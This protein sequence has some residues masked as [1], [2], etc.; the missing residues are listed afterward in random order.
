MTETDAEP[1]I[2]HDEVFNAA[3]SILGWDSETV[4]INDTLIVDTLGYPNLT[5]FIE[6]DGAATITLDSISQ[7]HSNWRTINETVKVFTGADSAI[8]DLSE[9]IPTAEALKYRYLKFK[10]NAAVKATLEITGKLFGSSDL[11]MLT[12]FKSIVTDKDTDFTTALAQFATKNEDITGLD[13]NKVTIYAIVIISEQQLNFRLHFYSEDTFAA[14]SWIGFIDL[15]LTSNGIQI[16]NTGKWLL[17]ITSESEGLL[18]Y[19]DE[20]ETKELHIALE[21]LSSAGKNA[22]A[23]GELMLKIFYK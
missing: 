3:L 21:N 17:N 13:L 7:D 8:I 18:L 9:V 6:V 10:I 4:A 23:A 22:G 14:A 1:Q 5:A 16:G 12:S 11:A 15:N 2:F 20:D 19:E